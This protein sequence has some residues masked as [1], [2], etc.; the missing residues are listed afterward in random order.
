VSTKPGAGHDPD[1]G[2]KLFL[3]E[4]SELRKRYGQ[5]I[6]QIASS[7]TWNIE[8]VGSGL[9][10][11]INAPGSWPADWRIDPV[12]L[13]CILRCAD[14][15][16]IDD[17]RAPDFLHA[18]TRREGISLQHWK[19]Q[20]WLARVD[21]DQADPKR[22]TLLFTSNHDF[23]PND[24]DAW[25]IAYDAIRLV[26]RE[27]TSSNSLLKLRPQ[28]T[29]SPEFSVKRV[30]GVSSPE[31][32]SNYLR[33]RG[34][35]PWHAELHVGN[36]EQLVKSLG[37]ENLYGSDQKQHF[38]IV[39]RELIQNSRD[40]VIAR[41]KLNDDF[42]GIIRISIWDNSDTPVLEI[43]D[44]GI[45]MSERVLTG[46]FLDFGS[47]FW[48]S[49][50][51][52]KEF[53]G[54]KSS[55]FRSVGRYGIGFYSVFMIAKNVQVA[56]RRWDRG[57]DTICSLN[58]PHGLTLRPVF[59]TGHFPEFHGTASTIIRCALK[60]NLKNKVSTH[61]FERPPKGELKVPIEEFIARLVCGLD[62]AIELRVNNTDWK[63]VHTPIEQI[64]ANETAK[65]DWLRSITVSKHF[66][67][68][69]QRLVVDGANRL[70]PIFSEG[71][72][73]G[74]AALNL[75]LQ[76][77]APTICGL[78]SIGGLLSGGYNGIGGNRQYLG[79]MDQQSKSAKREPGSR[80]ASEEELD[81]WVQDQLKLLQGRTITIPELFA[82][83]HHLCELNF[84]PS[85]FI[86]A[87]F[88]KGAQPTPILLTLEQVFERMKTEPI[89]FFKFNMMDHMEIH[90]AQNSYDN[91][92]TFKAT[93]NSSFL[94]L[95]L[96]GSVPKHSN[97]FIGCIYRRAKKD[98]YS[99]KF[100][101]H[102][103]VARSLVGAADVLIMSLDK[104]A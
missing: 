3:I 22:E 85:P 53:P 54:L 44:D 50:L 90:I 39:L 49:D 2:N 73:T 37:G 31:A 12:K 80:V 101:L 96:D 7:H 66:D 19:A 14:A 68:S 104:A 55:D 94:S 45:G 67:Q 98:G 62:V 20:N 102:A 92:L 21:L 64:I 87:L 82:L 24:A 88:F 41:R 100:E 78:H 74:L 81:K 4:D 29:I 26:D 30:A 59:S 95:E 42:Q 83:T 5:V 15:A 27:I 84:D 65:L 28:N 35:K 23:E 36:V 8:D 32:M 57:L 93:D 38:A 13:A 16:H 72:L 47:S 77:Q 70:R 79:F 6:G 46:P 99:L 58:F 60:A 25:W 17:R 43:A 76:S 9:P 52:N 69:I 61:I 10:Q 103:N 51:L 1:N 97:S 71:R 40:A 86:L 33:T 34:W 89:A 56:S 11:Q 18:L 63:R 48:K 91:Y 75:N